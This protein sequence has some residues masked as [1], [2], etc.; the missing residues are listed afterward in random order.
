MKYLQQ[1]KYRP[2]NLVGAVPHDKKNI[3]LRKRNAGILRSI[4]DE[5]LAKTKIILRYISYLLSAKANVD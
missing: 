1:L 5:T 4:L 3:V 2:R